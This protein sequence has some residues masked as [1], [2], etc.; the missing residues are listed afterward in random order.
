MHSL[1]HT[2][3]EGDQVFFVHVP[4]RL[5]VRS[6]CAVFV[7]SQLPAITAVYAGTEQLP[8]A[9]EAAVRAQQNNATSV[10]LALA[11]ARILEKVRGA[12]LGSI[13]CSSRHI[14]TPSSSA[15]YSWSLEAC[16]YVYAE[17]SAAAFSFRTCPQ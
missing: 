13:T 7:R 9:V 6:M 4:V 15:D 14:G 17:A 10:A 1:Q 12:A 8:A 11:A 16:V 2:A 3:S 5:H